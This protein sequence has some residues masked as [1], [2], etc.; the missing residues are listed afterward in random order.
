ML[1]TTHTRKLE[2]HV[3]LILDLDE[4]LIKG[5]LVK[6]DDKEKLEV[7][8]KKENFLIKVKTTN[9]W[10]YI[11]YRPYLFEFLAESNRL[12]NLYVVTMANI[13]Y[14]NLIIDAIS[15]K[16]GKNIFVGVYPRESYHTIPYKSLQFLALPNHN[17][18]I[19]DDN[20]GV[21]IFD[22]QHIVVANR[23]EGPDNDEYLS[24]NEL[25]RIFR[26]ILIIRQKYIEYN[27][28]V[29]MHKIMADIN[30][31]NI[32]KNMETI[33]KEVNPIEIDHKKNIKK[34]DSYIDFTDTE[35]DEEEEIV[36][37]LVEEILDEHVVQKILTNI[38]SNIEEKEKGINKDLIDQ[39]QE[40]EKFIDE[41]RYN[42]PK[43]DPI[44]IPL[45]I[46]LALSKNNVKSIPREIA[47]TI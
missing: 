46:P 23:F 2:H 31:A 29:G 17:S 12:F 5:I 32:I 44:A 21:W 14:S 37:E 9:S 42:I 11:Y 24:D 34:Y 4:T 36:K 39:D 6:D 47:M 28:H 33:S 26:Q 7:L 22:K 18:I 15:E 38:V 1:V 19:V 41:F 16:M 45:A 8:E 3:N 27:K 43:S 13:S 25:D 30:N 20:V 40:H 35:L 10:Y